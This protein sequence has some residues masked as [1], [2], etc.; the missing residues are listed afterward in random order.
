MP[1]WVVRL[2]AGI[3][4]VALLAVAAV[5]LITNTN[6]GRERVRR[7]VL[8]IIQ[9]NSHGI[10]HIGSVSGNLLNGFTL[11]DVVITDSARAP[12]LKA[13]EIWAK[14]SLSTLRGKKIDFS[15]VRLLNP[16]IV[17]S[18]IHI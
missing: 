15:E 4:V 14:Y 17:L 3:A 5:F 6:W 10:V 11:H 12:F 8:G 1:K 2:L 18:L 9:G 16:V 7:Y 13:D